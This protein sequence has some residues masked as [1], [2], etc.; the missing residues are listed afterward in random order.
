VLAV[1][2]V[3]LATYLK[4]LAEPDIIPTDVPILYF[5]AIVPTA[6]LFGLGPSIFVCVLSALAYDYFFIT[7][8]HALSFSDIA[9]APILVIFLSVALIVSYL[10]SHLRQ[11]NIQAA[12]EIAARKETEAELVK[13]RV[14]LE[15]LVRLRTAE[16]E[17]TNLALKE[18]EQRWSTTLASIGDGVIA[19]DTRGNVV[20]MNAV[21]EGL[22]GWN[23][24]EASGKPISAVFS[25]VNESTR[26]RVASPVDKVLEKGVVCGLA[27][28]TVLIKKDGSELAVDDSGA[29]IKTAEGKTTGVVLVFRDITQRRIAQEALQ[30]AKDELEANE[31]RLKRSQEIAHLGSWELDLRTNCL[32]WS[33]EAYRIFG[34]R[35]QEFG[36]TYEAFL[37]TVHPD[38]RSM[39]DSAFT[40]S[41]QKG[42]D[43]Y[44]IDHR[45]VRKD[46]GEIRQVHE[47][48]EHFRD[49]DGKVTLSVGMVHD[50]TER[51]RAE[52]ALKESEENLRLASEAAGV[53]AFDY[54]FSSGRG[55]YSRKI[56]DLLNIKAGETVKMDVDGLVRRIYPE[57]RPGALE[58]VNRAL[59]PAGDGSF[60]IE[61]RVIAPGGGLRWLNLA[62]Q[63]GFRETQGGRIPTRIRGA[64]VDITGLKQSQEALSRYASDLEASNKELESFGY[65]IS[66]DLRAPLR[67]MDGFAQALQEDYSEKLDA[68]G[69]DYLRR[70]RAAS[71]LMSRLIDDMLNLS[72]ITR[73][74]LLREHIN[75]SKMAE[76]ILAELKK[77]QPERRV[78]FSVAPTL[79]AEGD[80]SLVEILLKN[81][82]ENAWKFSGNSPLAQVS[83]GSLSKDGL[84]AYYV[85]DN[86]VGFDMQYATKLFQP[87]QRLHS[88]RDY[89]GTGVGLAIS[90]RIVQRHGGKIWV[91]SQPG[92]G[93]TFY[94][95]L[96]QV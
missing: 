76:D 49:A 79:V 52:E 10:A 31:A 20:F 47:R 26:E 18:S 11:R 30:S 7:P 80:R 5:L 2:L 39:V 89:P 68:N 12:A 87:F 41:L 73:S 65:S 27:N 23:L 3:A 74:E 46:T 61:C 44:E 22:T 6:I 50:I 25:I 32:T 29:P 62:G 55:Q 53:G 75:I 77:G 35:P 34:L 60:S 83:F 67:A 1:A 59:D 69:L 38:D 63:I 82:L 8:I 4:E 36:A 95:T 17:M 90:Q 57:D 21:A 78:Q 96:R 94:F 58:I 92:L 93:T 81:L 71:Q 86:G 45:I 37:A 43:C 85:K 84:M 42:R 64:A 24:A 56:R 70:I 14:H 54:D 48:C 40:T 16:L 9:A 15:E 91:E 13:Y 66:H 88:S 33:D 51:K 28:H 72:R 19:T